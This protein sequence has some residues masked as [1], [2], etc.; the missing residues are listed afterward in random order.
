MKLFLI[1]FNILLIA[2]IGVR[3]IFCHIYSNTFH[4]G[5][6]ALISIVLGAVAGYFLAVKNDDVVEEG[7]DEE[8][9]KYKLYATCIAFCT[10]SSFILA[11]NLNYVLS[12]SSKRIENT[13]IYYAQPFM[14]VRKGVLPEDKMQAT[15]FILWIDK[16]GKQESIRT[17]QLEHWEQLEKTQIPLTFR[18]G[19]F[20]FDCFLP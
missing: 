19:L 10:V 8:F 4:A 17:S 9:E 13:S 6:L 2:I 1:I 5:Y 16:N 7:N 18:K 11:F 20:G 12:F 3:A 14:G 15:D